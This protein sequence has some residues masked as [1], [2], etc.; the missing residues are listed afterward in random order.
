MRGLGLD[1][2]NGFKIDGLPIAFAVKPGLGLP[3]IDGTATMGMRVFLDGALVAHA[4]GYDRA[5]GR[6]WRHATDR[7]GVLLQRDGALVVERVPGVVTVKREI[8]G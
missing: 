6:V 8:A 2:T 3:V 5:N 7:A 4:V 1:S